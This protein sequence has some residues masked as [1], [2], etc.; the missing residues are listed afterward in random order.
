V[1]NLSPDQ[2]AWA[3]RFTQERLLFGLP[4]LVGGLLAAALLLIAGWPRWGSLQQQHQRLEAL[5]AKQSSLPLLETQ[6]AKAE[7]QEQAARDQQALLVELLAGQG[8]IRTFLAELSRAA[9]ATGVEIEL[10]EPVPA[11]P[12]KGNDAKAAKPPSD[13]LEALGYTITSVLLQVRGAYPN[14]LAFLRRMESLDLLVRPSDLELNGVA[15]ATDDDAGA[16][17]DTGPVLTEL[18]L[19]LSFYDTLPPKAQK[20]NEATTATPP[21]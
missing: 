7:Q 20:A 8:Q 11:K 4:I 14:V 1:T 19:L 12:E 15:S 13:P 17:E 9:R 6:L 21:S 5:R 16:D 10:Y 3:Q 2:P 18:K